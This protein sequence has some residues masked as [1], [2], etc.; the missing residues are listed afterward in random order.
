MF[1]FYKI[2]HILS[3]VL[4]FGPAIGAYWIVLRL[5]KELKVQEMSR[6]EKYYEQVLRFEH[7]A[8][9]LLLGSGVGMIGE[10]GLSYFKAPWIQAKLYLVGGIVLIEIFDIWFS[11][12]FFRKFIKRGDLVTD[13]EWK[14]FLKWRMIFYWI[15]VPPLFF[16]VLGIVYLAVV[17]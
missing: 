8:L 7:V 6:L 3:F 2:L 12:I 14:K 10:L 17:R 4:W 1:S 9:L 11:H 15:V 5:G 16:L 13:S